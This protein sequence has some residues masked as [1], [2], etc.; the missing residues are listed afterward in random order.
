[1]ISRFCFSRR[2]LMLAA[3]ACHG[4]IATPGWAQPA[5]ADGHDFLYRVAAGDTLID[6][7]QRFT[8]GS[9]HWPT[10]QSLNAVADPTRLPIGRVLKI[11]FSLIPEIP[12]RAQV[13]HVA[14]KVDLNGRALRMADQV[15]EGDA[16]ASGA[17]GFATLTLADNSTL[18]IPAQSSLHIERLRVFKGTGLTDTIFI[19]ERGSL[20]SEVAPADTGVGRF[21]VRTPVSITGVRGTRLR[22]HARENG[23]Q[24]EV[25][26]GSARLGS[27]AGQGATLRQGQGAAVDS[28]GKFLGVRPLLPAPHLP[29][30]APDHNGNTLSFS[31]VPGADAYLVR[32]AADP[33]GARLFSSQQFSAPPVQYAAPGPGTHYLLVRAI[34][35]DGVAG[36]DAVMPFEGRAVLKTSDGAAVSTSFGQFVALS[37]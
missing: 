36:M 8:D 27:G 14:G 34:D 29:Q 26:A 5:G 22:V 2:L 25:L 31:P 1:M 12:S 18:T 32:V 7:S 28:G 20:E 10:L 4:F 24:S 15:G 9:H 35:G 30:A 23:A 19:M 17:D 3:L 13:T 37:H 16:V 11:P 33:G 6:L 21:E